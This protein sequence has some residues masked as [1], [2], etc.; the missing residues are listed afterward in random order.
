MIEAGVGYG[1]R[2]SRLHPKMKPY[3][4]A[5]KSGVH[6]I[7]V[8]QTAEKLQSALDFLAKLKKDN[9][10]I[11]IVGTK[12]QIQSL[13]KDTA[14]ACGMPYVND[15]WLGGTLTNFKVISRRIKDL[16]EH[17]EKRERGEYDHYTKKERLE[18]DRE[19]E[20]LK[21]NFEGL[22]MMKELPTAVFIVD[23]DKNDLAARE[24]RR[25]Q[26]KSVALV[27]TN[28]NPESVDYPIPANDDAL[29]GVSFILEEVKKALQ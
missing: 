4:A 15:R 23:L 5:I 10:Q 22:K 8:A 20:R 17:E 9:K 1:H 21:K 13:V 12:V 14:E 7:D 26:I 27:D 16:I 24:A 3:V 25:K 19:I 2:T 28:L 29:S 6:L 18:I 11:L